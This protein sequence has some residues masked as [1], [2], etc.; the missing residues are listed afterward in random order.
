MRD[1][2]VVN[3]IKDKHSGELKDNEFD[4]VDEEH[5][6]TEPI[7]Y[8]SKTYK[9]KDVMIIT[10]PNKTIRGDILFRLI[11]KGSLKKSLICRFSFN[12]AFHPEDIIS[13]SIKELDPCSIKKDSKYSKDFRINLLT[14]PR[15]DD[16]SNETP[17]T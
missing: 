3:I 9:P 10:C 17:L 4:I 15:C 16:C 14:K 7:L 8:K 6:G 5:P 12:T 1:A 13:F 11:N 2:S